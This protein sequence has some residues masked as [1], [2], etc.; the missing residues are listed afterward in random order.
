M[1]NRTTPES[2]LSRRSLLAGSAAL[3]GVALAP[4]A[5]ADH[6]GQAPHRERARDGGRKD[7]RRH[8]GIQLYTVRAAMADDPIGSLTA[9]AGMGYREVEFAG[10][11]GVPPD[12]L[13]A[14]LDELRLASPS[15][16]INA[17]ELRDDPAALIEAAV[18]VGHRWLT[19]GWIEESDRQSLADW[20][21]WAAACNRASEVAR[22]AGIRIAYHNHD[23]ELLP[24]E[25]AEPLQLLLD[26]TDPAGV[27]FEL[28]FYWVRKAGASVRD[29]LR[30]A[31]ERFRL[32]HIKDMDESGAMADVGQ[33]TIDF[34]AI[35]ADPAA[36]HIAHPFVERDDA[37]DP[38][39]SAAISHHAMR[40]LLRK[41]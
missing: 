5:G 23:F 36:G 7:G 10:Y 12:E 38:F 14:T 2:A 13:R 31:P 9:I 3:A 1:T 32:A 20:R 39:K 28:D 27:D 19:I 17:R 21:S 30:R 22:D 6:H 16:H 34:S 18:T 33:G 40:A 8:T 35:L 29:V 26:E 37:P 15:A 41:G 11:H 24:M 25:G 4:A